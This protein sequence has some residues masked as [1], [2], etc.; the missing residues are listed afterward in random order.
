MNLAR[1]GRGPVDFDLDESLRAKLRA[2]GM[3]VTRPR[4]AVI[5]ALTRLG[6]PISAERLHERLE[7]RCDLVTVYRSLAAL[8]LLAVVQKLYAFNG[9]AVYALEPLEPCYRVLL[10]N[11]SDGAKVP[12]ETAAVLEAC[13]N[14]AA[15][16]IRGMG[17]EN[18]RASVQF[19]ADKSQ[20]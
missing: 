15:E 12:I 8:E 16:H 10:R 5:D 11:G 3:R 19:F 6:H 20:T 17:Y 9:T 7:G 4:I 1:A 13:V 18:V 14:S 2:R